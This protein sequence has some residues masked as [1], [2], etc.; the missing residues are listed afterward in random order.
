MA[1]AYLKGLSS[2]N[3]KTWAPTLNLYSYVLI[4]ELL[5]C[6]DFTGANRHTTE[7]KFRPFLQPI[8]LDLHYTGWY[9]E[10]EKSLLQA[11]QTEPNNQLYLEELQEMQEEAFQNRDTFIL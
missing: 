11:L 7:V 9:V 2:Y 8:G 1:E 6:G 4:P 10:V 3:P 5:R